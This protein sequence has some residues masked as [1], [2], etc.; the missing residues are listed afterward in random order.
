MLARLLLCLG[1]TLGCF[2]LLGQSIQAPLRKRL[3]ILW[4]CVNNNF[5]RAFPVI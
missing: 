5:A 4:S 1:L 2:T 3:F